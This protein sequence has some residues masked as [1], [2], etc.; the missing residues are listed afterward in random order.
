MTRPEVVAEAGHQGRWVMAKKRNVIAKKR[1]RASSMAI[2]KKIDK[3]GFEMAY[4]GYGPNA[5]LSDFPELKLGYD[6]DEIARL[7][8]RTDEIGR[9]IRDLKLFIL[10]L[11]GPEDTIRL[12]LSGTIV[13]RHIIERSNRCRRRPATHEGSVQWPK[14]S[15]RPPESSCSQ[16]SESSWTKA[17]PQ[18][19][20][21]W[22]P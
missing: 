19:R 8:E 22:I 15:K 20:L 9:L 1:K 17:S 14:H 18:S 3:D 12:Q 6:P 11:R 21:S 4:F 7:R 2:V 13:P 10:G 5:W 16:T